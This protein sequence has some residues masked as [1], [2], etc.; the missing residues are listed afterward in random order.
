MSSVKVE[1][2]STSEIL[3]RLPGNSEVPTQGRKTSGS[4]PPLPVDFLPARTAWFLH[5][6]P[7]PNVQVQ[8]TQTGY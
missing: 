1:P 8:L 3:N 5:L 2:I 7:P 4:L 6:R